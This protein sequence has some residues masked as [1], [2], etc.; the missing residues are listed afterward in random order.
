MK[1]QL[2]LNVG[3]Q[4]SACSAPAAFHTGEVGGLAEWLR[5]TCLQLAELYGPL[6]ANPRGLNLNTNST[7]RGQHTWEIFM[8]PSY[9]SLFFSFWEK[10]IEEDSSYCVKRKNHVSRCP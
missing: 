5:L 8:S 3:F 9:A 7:L 10:K 2:I 4:G 1:F 6:P